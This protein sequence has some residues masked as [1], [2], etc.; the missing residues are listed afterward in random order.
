MSPWWKHSHITQTVTVKTFISPSTF[1][2][3]SRSPLAPSGSG[4][5]HVL[6]LFSCNPS[7]S[8]LFPY[9]PHLPHLCSFITRLPVPPLSPYIT[10]STFLSLLLSLLLNLNPDQSTISI[11][12]TF[13]ITFLSYISCRAQ[14]RVILL[15]S[16]TLS[17]SLSGAALQ[18]PADW[19]R[20]FY[21]HWVDR[22][23]QMQISA[24][25]ESVAVVH[26]RQQWCLRVWRQPVS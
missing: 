11:S 26:P 17:P 21:S 20:A 23:A 3:G 13:F 12:C 16:L 22:W 18:G 1:D 6:P 2:P 15:F 24:G 5:F 25:I 7:S 10:T 4:W 14:C 8:G 9:K 19:I